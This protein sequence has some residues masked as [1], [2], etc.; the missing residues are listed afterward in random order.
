MLMMY[1]GSMAQW[2]EEWSTAARVPGSTNTHMHTHPSLRSVNSGPGLGPCSDESDRQAVDWRRGK[3]GVR[4][5]TNPIYISPVFQLAVALQLMWEICPGC[6]LTPGAAFF[7]HTLPAILW[8]WGVVKGTSL[9]L[10]RLHSLFI[11]KTRAE[12]LFACC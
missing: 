3:V 8:R 4:G 2:C 12:T 6:E 7:Y 5:E 9:C 1:K 11:V 10:P